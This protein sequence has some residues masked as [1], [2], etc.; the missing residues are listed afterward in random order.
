MC[1][2]TLQYTVKK[3]YDKWVPIYYNNNLSHS[4]LNTEQNGHIILL[5]ECQKQINE[6]CIILATF[7]Y[8]NL[9]I[10]WKTLKKSI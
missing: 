6:N 10:F 5:F 8:L 4:F 1:F 7:F 9:I 3:N 2:K